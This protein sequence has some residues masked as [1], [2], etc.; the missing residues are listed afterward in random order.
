M[1]TLIAVA[2]A[3][4]SATAFAKTPT[5]AQSFMRSLDG[6]KN[7]TVSQK[8]FLKPSIDEFKQIDTNGDGAIDKK[9]AEVYVERMRAMIME[10]IQQRSTTTPR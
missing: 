2:I 5:P 4:L 10:R 1:K 8:E 7:G 9:E 6:N 3:A